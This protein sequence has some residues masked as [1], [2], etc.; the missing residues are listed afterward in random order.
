MQLGV[1][2]GVII[3]R[4]ISESPR[5]KRTGDIQELFADLRCCFSKNKTNAASQQTVISHCMKCKVNMSRALLAKN[6]NE[7]RLKN[8][9][10]GH[11]VFE[12]EPKYM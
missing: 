10:G 4:D 3:G 6:F 11:H 8:G 5:V 2:S 1:G 12:N 7:K 9:Y